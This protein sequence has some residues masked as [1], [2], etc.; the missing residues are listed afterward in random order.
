MPSHKKPEK[1]RAEHLLERARAK[2]AR[3]KS[4]LV[5]LQKLERRKIS[6]LSKSILKSM[7]VPAKPLSG[8]TCPSCGMPGTSFELDHMGPWRQYV[9]ALAGPHISSGGYIRMSHVRILYNDPEN[10]W[11][12]CRRCNS[13][14]SDYI[15]EDGTVPT[16]GTRGR[17]V[18]LARIYK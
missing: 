11:W 6:W 16:S 1:T 12:I 17:D 5:N 9:A 2:R 13:R 14:K 8:S 4:N 10:L 7:G 15:S 3:F 18:S